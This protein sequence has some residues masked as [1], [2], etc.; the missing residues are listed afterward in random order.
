MSD[1]KTIGVYDARAQDYATLTGTEEPDETLRAF[2]AA[3]PDAARVLDLGCGPGGASAHM[4]K[5]GF[6]VDAWDASAAMVELASKIPGV[7]ARQARFDD[8]DAI[9]EYDAVWANFSL[10]HAPL[11]EIPSH[12]TAIKRALKSGGLF[13]IAVKEGEGENRDAIGR[14]YSYF[15]RDSLSD[16]LNQAGLTPGPWKS[17]RDKGLSGKIDPWIATLAH[18]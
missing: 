9:G 3:L 8:L 18:A 7:S 11:A 6:Q 4:A 12:L 13:H 1:P 17:G 16:L 14:R 5:A 10:L 2:M 15:T